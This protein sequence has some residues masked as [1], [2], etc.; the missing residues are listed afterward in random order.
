VVEPI[1]PKAMPVILTTEEE[2][3]VWLREPRDEAKALQ[4]LVRV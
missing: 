1:Y 3:E 4:Q 2:R